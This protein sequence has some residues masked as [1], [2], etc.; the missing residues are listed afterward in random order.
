MGQYELI[1]V[2][3]NKNNNFHNYNHS[4][5]IDHLLSIL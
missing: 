3:N 5:T 1:C 4:N 2:D